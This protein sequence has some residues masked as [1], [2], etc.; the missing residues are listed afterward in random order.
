MLDTVT[1]VALKLYLQRPES[2]AR[3]EYPPT[4]TVQNGIWLIIS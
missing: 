2:V 3:F 4:I 1:A